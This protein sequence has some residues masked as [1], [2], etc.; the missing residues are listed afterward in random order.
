MCQHQNDEVGEAPVQQSC[1]E[2]EVVDYGRESREV[3]RDLRDLYM[4]KIRPVEEI[5]SFSRVSGGTLDTGDFESPPLLLL[6]GPYS[7]GK[8]TFI[9][10]LVGK[11][12]PGERI[13]PEPT[14]D[15]FVAIMNGE[16][17]RIVP[18]NALTVTPGTPFNGLQKFGN[19]FLT[20]FEGSQVKDSQ[21]LKS[22]TIID[23]PGVLSGVKQT[24]GRAYKYEDVLDWFAERSDMIILL[25]DVQKL[26]ISDEMGALIK[27]IQRHADKI[28]VVLNKADSISHQNLLKVYGA[29]LWSLGRVITTPEVTRVYIGSFWRIPLKNEETRSLMEQEMTD[30]LL[31]LGALPR[32]AAVRRIN[33]MVKRIREV[34]VH[35]ILL[36][37]LRGRMPSIGFKKDRKKQELLDNLPAIFREVMKEQELPCG[38]FPDINR[39]KNSLERADLTKLPKL[40]GSRMMQGKRMVDLNRSLKLAIPDLLERLPG[41][42]SAKNDSFC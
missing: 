25:F 38:D 3:M 13:G 19:N 36:D 29:L 10:H 7:A 23:T 35:A 14:T 32:L 15:K 21:L 4:N 20:R 34:R 28:R 11:K 41:I 24:Q 39:F 22:L 6:L 17:E 5:T 37:H 2:L 42:N 33:D 8:T 30:L 9:E 18:G 40:K 12:F 26:D 16:E 31:D 1:R 27:N